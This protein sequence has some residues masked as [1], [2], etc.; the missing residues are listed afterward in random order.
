ML[1]QNFINAMAMVLIRGSTNK[2]MLPL[3]AY[4]GTV[5]YLTPSQNIPVNLSQ[6]FTLS[7]SSTGI[8]V[9][10]GDT[11]PAITDYQLEDPITSNL[12]ASVV[13]YTDTDNNGNP[14]LQYDI[15]ITNNGGSDVTIREIGYRQNLHGATTLGGTGSNRVCLIDRTVLAEPVTI[16]ANG[17]A[18]IRYTLKTVI[19]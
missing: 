14:Y 5:Y 17:I 3:T 6:S 13:Q 2:G 18:T 19:L 10:S 7:T 8:C 11:A 12:Q 16:A 4:N 1:T 9:G 15:T